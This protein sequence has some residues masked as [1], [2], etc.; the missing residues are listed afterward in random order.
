MKVSHFAFLDFG[1]PITGTV[2]ASLRGSSAG[3]FGDLASG[4]LG[5]SLDAESADEENVA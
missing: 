5:V 3:K 2:F 4:L 1:G